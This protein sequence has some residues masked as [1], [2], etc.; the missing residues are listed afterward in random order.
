VTTLSHEILLNS[1]EEAIKLLGKNG[2]LRKRLQ[3]E[4]QVKIVDRGAKIVVMGDD[5]GAA[6]ANELLTDML[7]AVR[8]GHTPTLADLNYALGELRGRKS[9]GV[10]ELLGAQ[11][12]PAIRSDIRIRPRTH[13]QRAYLDAI[14]QNEMTLVIG[15]AGTGKT[16]LAMAAAVSALLSKQVQ[17]LVLTRPAVE[18]GENLGF[19]PGDLE[20]K[21]SPYL[22]PLYDALYSMVDMDKVTRFI[23][24]QRIEV[25]PLAFM[26]GRTLDNAFVILDEAQNT[27]PDQMLMFLTRL[28]QG[29]RAVIT[30]DVT[31]ID[32]PRGSKSGL[33]EAHR[34]L[35]DIPGIGIVPLTKHDVVR[36]PLVQRIID[37]Y[38]SE[39]AR[40]TR[41][42]QGV[43][44]PAP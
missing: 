22:R 28:G 6:T 44:E 25:A 12:A 18:A 42:E 33:I 27:T 41:E 2:E 26:R 35:K 7:L 21:V 16:Y 15:P 39:K 43:R 29:S 24:Q 14:S 30:G 13:G 32:L 5:V 3:D 38:E 4:A 19:L 34:I 20:Q 36:N 31:Q 17:R 8:N 9:E 40:A 37:A 23:E 10:G 1:Q 11:T